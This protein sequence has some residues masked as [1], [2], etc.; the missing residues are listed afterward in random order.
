M[1]GHRL[2]C[3]VLLCLLPACG[4]LAADKHQSDASEHIPAATRDIIYFHRDYPIFIRM[5]IEVA[6]APFDAPWR[7]QIAAF[8]H[9]VDRDENGRLSRDEIDAQTALENDAA[10]EE[11]VQLLRQPGLWSADRRP[12]DGT[13]DQEELARFFIGQ[14]RGP[15]QVPNEQASRGARAAYG[16]GTAGTVLFSLL[17]RSSDGALSRDEIG[18]AMD[19]L[20]RRDLDDDGTFALAELTPA[21][22]SVLRRREESDDGLPFFTLS[23]GTAPT[24]LL[25][26]LWRRY[27]PADNKTIGNTSVASR[28]LTAS[29]LGIEPRVFARYDADSN[30]RLDVEE[31]RYLVLNPTPNLEL[32]V[33]LGQR[34]RQSQVVEVTRPANKPEISVRRAPSGLASVTINDVQLEIAEVKIATDVAR[35]A[36]LRLFESAD[37]DSNNYLEKDELSTDSGFAA[38]FDQFDRDSDGRLFAEEVT[39]VVDRRTGF[40]GSRTRLTFRNRGRDL[41][42]ILDS[43]RN[44]RLGRGE[45]VAATSRIALWDRDGTGTISESEVPQLY[46][47][48]LGPGQPEFRGF[49]DLNQTLRAAGG[50]A[51]NRTGPRW[52]QRMDRNRDGE[53]ARREF[54]G[55]RSEF[56]KIDLNAD[57]VVDVTEAER[58]K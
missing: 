14:N 20:R 55:L 35:Q 16:T 26:Q 57:G 34:D 8:F 33:R 30:S 22:N 44:S 50:S 17:D 23:P 37:R 27:G 56:Q 13:I 54:P 15:L 41:F 3:L 11:L 58:I 18:Q 42:Q 5:T 51:S 31:L 28:D 4:A 38:S 39:S 29:D 53:L 45:V 46:Q 52:F 40:A 48:S 19:S 43:D 47:L 25:R 12:L 9:S 49:D 10:S 32:L 6:G 36:M 1:N 21:S 2:L 7:K 24:D